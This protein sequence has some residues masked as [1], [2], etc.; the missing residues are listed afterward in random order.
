MLSSTSTSLLNRDK[1]LPIGV[2]SKKD[3]GARNIA[4]NIV[5]CNIIAALSV[6]KRGARSTNTDENALKNK[7]KKL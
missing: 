6:P 3:N 5:K 2:V 1:S 7:K 4:H